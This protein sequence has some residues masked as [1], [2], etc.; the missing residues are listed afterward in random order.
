MGEAD[1]LRHTDQN[2]A[3]YAKR[4]ETM[5]RVFEDA[6]EKHGTRWTTLSGLGKMSMQPMQNSLP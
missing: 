6:K 3:I 2:K 4:K 5:E 1:H